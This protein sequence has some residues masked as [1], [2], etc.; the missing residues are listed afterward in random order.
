MIVPCVEPPSSKLKKE[1]TLNDSKL[2][3]ST[4]LVSNDDGTPSISTVGPEPSL[5][6][7]LPGILP[8]APESGTWGTRQK[9]FLRPPK[10][11]GRKNSDESPFTARRSQSE[12]T[13]PPSEP[14]LSGHAAAA[15]A[16]AA[17]A[18]REGSLQRTSSIKEA[19]S[20]Q[21]DDED[22]ELHE[23]WRW[24]FARRWQQEQ[25]RTTSYDVNGNDDDEW[26]AA[27]M[28]LKDSNNA[29]LQ[30]QLGR[31]VSAADHS[32]DL[33]SPGLSLLLEDS[34]Q[35]F[36]E[37]PLLQ[38]GSLS[39]DA[40]SSIIAVASRARSLAREQA[41]I[42]QGIE[43]QLE[44]AAANWAGASLAPAHFDTWG[45]FPFILAK[46]I[47]RNGRQKVVVRGKNGS[48]ESQTTVNLTTEVNRAA[49]AARLPSPKI[50]ILGSGSLYWS[51]SEERV[52]TVSCGVLRTA[53]DV[54]VQSSE[55]VVLICADLVRNCLPKH[56]AVVTK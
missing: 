15:A 19:G 22:D 28:M 1:S 20:V 11:A 24:R 18:V 52:L 48:D 38:Q 47:D 49:V 27:E 29:G 21:Q 5:R 17:A 37:S 55:D 50:E 13:T 23:A 36:K 3:A 53:M 16:A 40:T 30:L 10:P 39:Q 46:I 4:V 42:D 6:M 44:A 56:I 26:T 7:D 2:S 31:T 41:R 54:R 45:R 14:S 25:E 9:V 43:R 35:S 51:R 8:I 33:R 34:L 12:F 32:A